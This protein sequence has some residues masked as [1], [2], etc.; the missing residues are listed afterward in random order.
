MERDHDTSNNATCLDVSGDYSS[1][2]DTL[3]IKKYLLSESSFSSM[4]EF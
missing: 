2:Q 3:F 4:N 1:M